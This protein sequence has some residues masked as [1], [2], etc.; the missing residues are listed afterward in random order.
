MDE[1]AK[2]EMRNYSSAL[3]YLVIATITFLTALT[4]TSGIEWFPNVVTIMTMTIL[5][6]SGIILIILQKRDLTALTFLM[7]AMLY[8]FISF[9]DGFATWSSAIVGIVFLL[10]GCVILT[11]ADTKKYYLSLLPF[12]YGLNL[13]SAPFLAGTTFDVAIVILITL[14]SVYFTFAVSCE[15]I[16]LPGG[17]ALKKDVVTNFKTSGSILGY[18]LF[19]LNALLWS[20]YYFFGEEALPV[21]QC[22]TLDSVCGLMMILTGILLFAVAKMRFTP[23][24]FLALGFL[25]YIGAFVTDVLLNYPI[26]LMFIVLAIMAFLRNEDRNFVGIMLF[27]YGISYLFA[28]AFGEIVS[29]AAGIINIIPAFMALYLAFAIVNPKKL[30]LF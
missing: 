1:I 13:V 28:A 17:D 30:P 2:T 14:V 18:L 27:I 4:L 5:L 9:G 29:F 3:G 6:L 10:F 24:M 15:K 26:G 21:E 8:F 20:A 11:A 23:V 12:L 25:I 22:L 19:T 16:S 7:I